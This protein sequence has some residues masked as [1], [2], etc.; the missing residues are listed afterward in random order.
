M[1]L[2][3]KQLSLSQRQLD[4]DA[5]SRE[6]Y[7]HTELAKWSFV[8]LSRP[9]PI[10]WTSVATVQSFRENA[11]GR[12]VSLIMGWELRTHPHKGKVVDRGPHKAMGEL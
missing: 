5:L 2:N 10:A 7:V 3:V 1:M 6:S 11:S 4:G 9:A 8:D 12:G